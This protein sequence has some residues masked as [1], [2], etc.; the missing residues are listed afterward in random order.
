MRKYLSLAIALLCATSS[1]NADFNSKYKSFLNGYLEAQE[2]DYQVMYQ[3]FLSEYQYGFDNQVSE[4][5]NDFTF[6]KKN[7]QSIIAHN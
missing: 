3:D 7:M 4:K 6:F 2:Q 5:S 1:V